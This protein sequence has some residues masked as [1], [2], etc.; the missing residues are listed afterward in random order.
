VTSDVGDGHK[1]GVDSWRQV[2]LQCYMRERVAK[3]GAATPFACAANSRR[4]R[5]VHPSD[6]LAE[7]FCELKTQ[8]YEPQVCLGGCIIT[9]LVCQH[10]HRHQQHLT[11]P[12]PTSDIDP[13]STESSSRNA[14]TTFVSSWAEYAD[15][16]PC[17]N[18]N[19][20]LKPRQCGL[21]A[22]DL[23]WLPLTRT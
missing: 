11:P 8:S 5:R 7:M 1:I 2:S 20:Q 3:R 15:A 17:R 9:C 16:A 6:D 19:F 23:M 10:K 14:D 13:S 22:V 12:P 18:A 21:P 4:W